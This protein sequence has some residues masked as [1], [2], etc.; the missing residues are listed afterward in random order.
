MDKDIGKQISDL[1]DQDKWHE[2]RGLI[3]SALKDEPDDHWLLDRLSLTYYEQGHYT[4]SLHFIEKAYK[5][6]PDCPLVLWDYA[7]TLDML[8]DSKAALKTYLRLVGMGEKALAHDFHGEGVAWARSLLADC[9]YRIAFC[10]LDM[11]KPLEALAWLQGHLLRRE[12]GAASIYHKRDVL[13]MLPE[14]L[15]NVETLS[16]TEVR[17]PPRVFLLSRK[18]NVVMAESPP[19]MEAGWRHPPS[20][21]EAADKPLPEVCASR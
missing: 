3:R 15:Q 12:Q 2:S 11:N 4:K 9:A 1:I 19:P 7:G 14:I 5:L 10:Y 18:G 16:A 20:L 6:A 17:E 21:W 8:R 13:R